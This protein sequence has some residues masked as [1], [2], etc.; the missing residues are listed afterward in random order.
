MTKFSNVLIVVSIAALLWITHEHVATNYKQMKIIALQTQSIA[1]ENQGFLIEM[2]INRYE[3]K[4]G[5]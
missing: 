1:L 5:E 3:E 2:K 4:L